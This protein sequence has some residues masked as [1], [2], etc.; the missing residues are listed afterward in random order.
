MANGWIDVLDSY[1]LSG[2]AIEEDRKTP[3]RVAIYVDGREIALI[4]PTL[5]RQDLCELGF[6]DGWV[7]FR[8]YFPE[9]IGIDEPARVVARALSSGEILP[10]RVDGE[11]LREGNTVEPN[12]KPR[13]LS[14]VRQ[15]EPARPRPAEAS[16]AP[17]PATP[18]LFAH[19][20][21][22][23]LMA[24][25]CS[26]GL[27]CEF[28]FAQNK[29]GADPFD[30][31]RW[32][33][34]PLPILIA[35][36]RQR[37]AG[38][39]DPA[40]LS[41]E[42]NQFGEYMVCNSRYELLWHSYVQKDRMTPERLL[43]REAARLPRQSEM[44]IEDLTAGSRIFVRTEHEFEAAQIEAL[45]AALRS[46]GPGTLLLVTLADAAH[47]CGTVEVAG[48][49]LL[50]GYIAEFADLRDVPAYT[51]ADRWLRICENAARLIEDGRSLAAASREES[52]AA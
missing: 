47:P 39:G 24:R 22:G 40:N 8:F 34:T 12:L 1:H 16:A 9:P 26:L 50:R 11:V 13:I 6:G 36:L 21:N 7:G 46:Y 41:V 52:V 28:G 49:R 45:R 23:A 30:L 14:H 5:F 51:R 2:W 42:L 15:G 3:E 35:L 17:P 25:F 4:R 32:A 29:C 19:A 33:W 48:D 31:F 18:S 10:Q 37:F 38:L 43:K 20:A 27:N 44:L